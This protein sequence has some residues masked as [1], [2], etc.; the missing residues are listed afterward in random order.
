MSRDIG[1]ISVDA[2]IEMPFIQSLRHDGTAATYTDAHGYVYLEP[3]TAHDFEL[4]KRLIK[5][6]LSAAKVIE[7]SPGKAGYL[8]YNPSADLITLSAV[9]NVS[10][11]A[12]S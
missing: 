4:S 5:H 8:R 12:A 2:L 7:R 11:Q 6:G 10:K 1:S 9:I 3:R